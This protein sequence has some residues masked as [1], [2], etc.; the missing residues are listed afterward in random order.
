LENLLHKQ[1]HLV[2]LLVSIMVKLFIPL[3]LLALLTLQHQSVTVSMFVLEV[4]VLVVQELAVVVVQVE[5]Q[6]PQE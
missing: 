2:V 6:L 3:H 5:S 4:V 1:K